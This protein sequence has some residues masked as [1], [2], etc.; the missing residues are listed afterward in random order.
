MPGLVQHSE[1]GAA[2]GN[3][4]LSG[5]LR[6]AR[7]ADRRKQRFRP[8]SRSDHHAAGQAGAIRLGISRALIE[9]QAELRG[10]LKQAGFLTRDSREVERKKYGRAGARKRFQYGKR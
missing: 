7:A 1:C 2:E 8:A 9:M 6:A 3:P 5:E 10:A 4:E